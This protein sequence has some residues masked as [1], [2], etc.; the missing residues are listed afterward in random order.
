MWNIVD[1]VM[2]FS[3][4]IYLAVPRYAVLMV[5]EYTLDNMWSLI[6]PIQVT[7]ITGSLTLILAFFRLLYYLTPL[8]FLGILII[9]I[10]KM[11]SDILKFLIIFILVVLGFAATFHLSYNENAD[12]INFAQSFMAVFISST[13]GYNIPPV[14]A[15]TLALTEPVFAVFFQ[16]LCLFIAVILLLNLLIA[17]MGQ[18]Y[19]VMNNQAQREYRWLMFSLLRQ[20]TRS[21]WPS[22][23]NIIHLFLVLGVGGA[24]YALNLDP[25]YSWYRKSKAQLPCSTQLKEIQL[26]KGIVRHYYQETLEK[27]E[28]SESLGHGEEED[29]KNEDKE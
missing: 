13:S 1:L 24:F 6:Y 20:L 7:S 12:Y 4:F 15:N 3:G 26:F 29:G 16:L 9:T 14:E 23:L 8:E 2:I 18:T 5:P 17:I 28:Y 25:K 27:S 10:F 11:L 19:D 21:L 22:P